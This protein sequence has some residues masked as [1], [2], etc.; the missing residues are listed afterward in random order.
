MNLFF[1]SVF[2][3]LGVMIDNPSYYLYILFS[4]LEM[5]FSRGGGGVRVITITMYI[6][7][8]WLFFFLFLLL[9]L[10][11]TWKGG[12]AGVDSFCGKLTSPSPSP[13]LSFIPFSDRGIY[14]HY[15]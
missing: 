14:V 7:E 12:W 8:S 4:S 1:I 2:T 11:A 3:S 10:S 15:H 5:P 6:P 9:K 13:L